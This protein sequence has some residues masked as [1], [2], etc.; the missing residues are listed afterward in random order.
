MSYFLI[1]ALSLSL[2][3]FLPCFVVV[4][5]FWGGRRSNVNVTHRITMVKTS[6]YLKVFLFF[7]INVV[8]DSVESF[9]SKRLPDFPR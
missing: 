8:G 3:L 2:S 1:I 5:F 9:S 6:P 4:G 7:I